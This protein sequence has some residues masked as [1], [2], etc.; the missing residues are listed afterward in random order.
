[1]SVPDLKRQIALL[2]DEASVLGFEFDP[3][4]RTAVLTVRALTLPEG[5]GPAGSTHQ[6]RFRNL[7]RLAAS[8]R[9][10]LWSD[11]NA[12]VEPL[13]LS[14]LSS[15][16]DSFGPR[17]I[18]GE[19]FIDSTDDWLRLWGD[20]LSLDWQ[21]APGTAARYSFDFFQ[22]GGQARHLDVRI[23]FDDVEVLDEF[24]VPE[25]LEQ[26]AEAALRWWAALRAGDPRTASSGI[27]PL[28]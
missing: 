7:T 12:P 14:E 8:L 1:M 4:L 15:V 28:K 5:D 22:E 16:I 2:L 23:W 19:H 10:G 24:G 20:R 27:I 9:K 25:S 13:E 21:V 17:E 6:L 3:A 26:V 11:R 18:Y